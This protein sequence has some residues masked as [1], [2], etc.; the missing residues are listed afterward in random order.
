MSA[1]K[2]V[3]IEVVQEGEERFVLT[4]YEDGRM[5][6]CRV[7]PDRKP[8]RKPRKPIARAG[9]QRLD[10]TRRKRF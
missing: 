1:R 10:K 5:V 8:T 2:P 9:L 7:D 4:T 3:S 6:R